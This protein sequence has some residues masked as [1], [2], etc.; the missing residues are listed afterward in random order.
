MF[1]LYT[2]FTALAGG[3]KAGKDYCFDTLPPIMISFFS[4]W[5]LKNKEITVSSSFLTVVKLR[6]RKESNVGLSYITQH[7]YRYILNPNQSIFT[8]KKSEL[9]NISTV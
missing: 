4:S 9:C 1:D 7:R 8:D 2:T 5:L 6:M 3:C